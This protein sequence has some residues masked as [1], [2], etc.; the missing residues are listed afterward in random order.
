[1]SLLHRTQRLLRKHAS[2][3][4]MGT[5]YPHPVRNRL[6]L[7]A[8]D[9][10][11]GTAGGVLIDRE[12]E[13]LVGP[14]GSPIGFPGEVAPTTEDGTAKEDIWTTRVITGE[15]VNQVGLALP[16]EA[17]ASDDTGK[18][19]FSL[20]RL[21]PPANNGSVQSDPVDSDAD[22]LP[23]VQE[24]E[25]EEDQAVDLGAQAQPKDRGTDESVPLLRIPSGRYKA[26]LGDL[27][28]RS[29][30]TGRTRARGSFTQPAQGQRGTQVS[31]DLPLGTRRAA[32][33]V[34]LGQ[35]AR[36]FAS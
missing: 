16:T 8:P 11:R 15:K 32:A 17:S 24:E 19:G 23:T 30:P 36:R 21:L 31:K 18:S 33:P 9:S 28:D 6:W 27:K 14:N 2:L 26:S 29:T 13:E 34:P 35:P 3:V 25:V 1:M 20:W 10:R 4:P 12:A 5:T 22:R 7:G